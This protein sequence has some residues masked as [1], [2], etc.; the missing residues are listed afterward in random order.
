M[1]PWIA[2][3]WNLQ[4]NVFEILR[5]KFGNKNQKVQ[6]M[7][8]ICNESSGEEGVENLLQN[9]SSDNPLHLEAK[10]KTNCI[11]KRRRK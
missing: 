10:K 3:N 2:R 11:L 1:Q 4:Q 5:T 7:Y 6:R 8:G 9:L